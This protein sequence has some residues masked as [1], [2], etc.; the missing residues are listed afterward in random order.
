MSHHFICGKGTGPVF[1]SQC[2]IAETL[3]RRL[4]CLTAL[5][6][7]I[8]TQGT[9]HTGNT[10]GREKSADSGRYQTYE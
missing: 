8:G 6:N 4:Y 7:D 5:G 2:V 9:V 1:L 3:T 10:N